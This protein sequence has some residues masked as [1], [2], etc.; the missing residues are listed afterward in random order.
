[1]S[2]WTNL[3]QSLNLDGLCDEASF[4]DEIMESQVE[5]E[6]D[7]QKVL[8]DLENQIEELKDHGMDQIIDMEGPM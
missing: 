8:H 5:V 4:D 2:D 6:D 1:L 7:P 3:N